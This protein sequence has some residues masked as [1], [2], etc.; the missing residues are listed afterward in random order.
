M[1]YNSWFDFGCT[2]AMNESSIV[3]T[4]DKMVSFGLRALG[5]R[6]VN[7]DGCWL[8]EGS[9]GRDG[10]GTLQPHARK[11]GGAVGIRRLADRLHAADMLFGVYTDRGTQTCQ[12]RVGSKGFEAADAKA[13]AAW[14]VDYVKSDSCH[15]SQDH[16]VAFADYSLMRDALNAT[17]RRIFFA[18]CGWRSWYA[19]AGAAIGNAARIGPDTISWRDILSNVDAMA[20]DDVASNPSGPGYWN[21]PC[22][23]VSKRLNGALAVSELQSRAQFA[24]W[25]IFSAPL[26]ISGSL[27]H[28][29]DY[30]LATYANARAISINQVGVQGMRLAGGNVAASSA[31]A[32]SNSTSINVWG[33]RVSS[34]EWALVL[35]NAGSGAA[36]LECDATC[37]SKI[38]I[39]PSDLPLLITDVWSNKTTVTKQL[40]VAAT[41]LPEH[42]GHLFVTVKSS[43]A[44]LQ[45]V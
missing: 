24:L 39:H 1:G 10:A 41:A 5:Y 26:L 13:Y 42:G 17:G 38:G 18:L 8:E 25:C 27:L 34:T 37:L 14:H 31:Q 44:A 16:A 3:A 15:A 36:D 33:K 40:N 21:D 9:K 43:S 12:G 4:A 7:L 2:D 45:V 23:L 6:F 11:F 20:S 30:T 28:M 32:A 35:L 29:S 22:L 19:P